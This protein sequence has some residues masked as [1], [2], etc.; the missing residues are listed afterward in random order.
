[1]LELVNMALPISFKIFL[2]FAGFCSAST[3]EELAVCK[4]KLVDQS[5]LSQACSTVSSYLWKDNQIKSALKKMLHHLDLLDNDLP[6][7]SVE[8]QIILT[9]SLEDIRTLREFVNTDKG[10]ADDVET[11]VM[12]SIEVKKS[13]LELPRVL[14][15]LR[16][17]ADHLNAGFVIIFQVLIITNNSDSQQ[18]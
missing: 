13:W 5:Y 1:M 6:S 12:R 7:G 9:L 4:S 16:P 3:E 17:S 18:F 2:F 8:K 15:G 10:S 11:I 14:P